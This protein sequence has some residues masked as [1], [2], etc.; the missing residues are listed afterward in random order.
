ML[1]KI[2]HL[3]LFSTNTE[4]A[5]E[6]FERVGF[7]YSH[8]FE[9]MHWFQL[10]QT[11]IML[12]PA[13]EANP[14]DTAIH[15]AVKDVHTLFNHVVAQDLEPYEH[16]NPNQMLS[17]PVTQPWGDVEFELKTP[18]GHKIAFTQIK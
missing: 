16:S 8:G 5:K 2:H 13:D 4:I 9:G 6:W 15:I 1:E 17:E 14:G 3:V 12:H 11:E 10:G 7:A 18:D